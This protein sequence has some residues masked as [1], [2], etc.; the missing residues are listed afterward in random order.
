MASR[1]SSKLLVKRGRK[2]LLVRRTKDGRWTLPGGKRQGKETSINCL[3]RELR[4][5]L[6]KLKIKDKARVLLERG[7]KIVFAA[8]AKG[9][10]KIGDPDEIDKAA[11]RHPR[12][13]RL[14]TV[15]RWA[16]C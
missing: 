9:E 13:S 4:E 14:T 7:N 1:K 15:A 2:A 8:R 10:L 5:E 11:W 16:L 3:K 6:P 12:K